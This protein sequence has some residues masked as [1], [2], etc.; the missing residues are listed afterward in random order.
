MYFHIRVF[1]IFLI[2]EIEVMEKF[3][4]LPITAYKTFK[5]FFFQEVYIINSTLNVQL[6]V[7]V[8]VGNAT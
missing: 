6:L 7:F 1:I 8:Y 4:L 3:V 2:Q 5:K